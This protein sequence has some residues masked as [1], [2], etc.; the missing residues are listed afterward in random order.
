MQSWGTC[1]ILLGTYFKIVKEKKEAFLEKLYRY[2]TIALMLV[3]P[4]VGSFLAV[5]LAG[6][7]YGPMGLYCNV[8]CTEHVVADAFA[9]KSKCPLRLVNLY[10]PVGSYFL[11]SAFCA[12]PLAWDAH[13]CAMMLSRL[14]GRQ[15]ASAVPISRDL[16]G[17][18]DAAAP[19][20]AHAAAVDDGRQR[21]VQGA[22][23]GRD[24]SRREE[25]RPVRSCIRSHPGRQLGDADQG[26]VRSQRG[27][28]GQRWPPGAH[29]GLLP[30]QDLA[31]RSTFV[32]RL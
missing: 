3:W 19:Q 23:R 10:A 25:G 29:D 32:A 13:G 24:R 28:G 8:R 1:V 16:C 22:F 31:Y 14:H 30:V 7:A 5:V 2:S 9:S 12:Q 4:L 20:G 6:D 17:G 15:G 26:N 11:Q 18:E 27:Q 21:R